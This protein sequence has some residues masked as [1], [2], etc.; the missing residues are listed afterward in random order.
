M[1]FEWKHNW[2]VGIALPTDEEYRM[3]EQRYYAFNEKWQEDNPDKVDYSDWGCGL[4]FVMATYCREAWW[5]FFFPNKN[6]LEELIDVC[7]SPT[8]PL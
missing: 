1:D 4:S 6:V 5:E 3:A 8:L 7:Q 2:P